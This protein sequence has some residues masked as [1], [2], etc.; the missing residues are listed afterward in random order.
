MSVNKTGLLFLRITTEPAFE[1]KELYLG[2][3]QENKKSYIPN[4]SS[5]SKSLN[6]ST[7]SSIHTKQNTFSTK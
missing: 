6:K 7:I 3:K 4:I 2:Q 1:V 5:F